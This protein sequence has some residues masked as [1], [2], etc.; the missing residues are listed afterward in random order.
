MN[1]VVVPCWWDGTAERYILILCVLILTSFFISLTSTIHFE[2]PDMVSDISNAVSIA[3]NPPPKFFKS[4][5]YSFV[6]CS[7]IIIYLFFSC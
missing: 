2:R 6:S 4:M 5:R 3:L 7:Y 1:L